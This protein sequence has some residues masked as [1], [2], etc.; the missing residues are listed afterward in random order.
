MTLG[1]SADQQQVAVSNGA[2]E[3]GDG[4][5]A[6]TVAAPDIGQ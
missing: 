3:V 1:A 4:H 6:A 2:C 5:L